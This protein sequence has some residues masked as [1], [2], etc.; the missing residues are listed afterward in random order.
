MNKRLIIKLCI[1]TIIAGIGLVGYRYMTLP[2]LKTI[3]SE[4]IFTK[5]EV[6]YRKNYR[7]LVRNDQKINTDFLLSKAEYSIIYSNLFPFGKRELGH[8]KTIELLTILNDSS[9]Y[10]WGEWGTPEYSK[11]IVF[12]N[13]NHASIGF[14]EWQSLGEADSYPYRSLM[15]WGGLTKKG[16][17]KLRGIIENGG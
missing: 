17:E 6:S 7:E 1:I 9:T 4:I 13:S 8:T 15:K 3:K 12:F 2:N 16:E 5:S 10:A 14:T 11:T